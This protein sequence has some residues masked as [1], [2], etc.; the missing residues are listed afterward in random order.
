MHG[1][2]KPSQLHVVV[3]KL[4]AAPRVAGRSL[5]DQG[6]KNP[7]HHLQHEKHRRRAAEDVPP[8][9]GIL[10]N[11][12]LNGFGDGLHQPEPFLEPVVN[13]DASL[14]QPWH[15]PPPG[16]G[17]PNA[18]SRSAEPAPTIC[19]SGGLTLA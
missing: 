3:E 8:T 15:D 7:G 19:V 6:E 1:A 18:A 16:S 14:P 5:I 2:Q 10:R 17:P 13:L 11:L 9:R 4:E 12:M